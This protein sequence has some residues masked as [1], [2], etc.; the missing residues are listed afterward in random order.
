MNLSGMLILA[1]FYCSQK[2][3]LIKKR[4][5]VLSLTKSLPVTTRTKTHIQ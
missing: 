5:A 4:K 2:M 1:R 3:I